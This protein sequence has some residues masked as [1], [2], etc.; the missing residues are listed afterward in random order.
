MARNTKT[1]EAAFL[2]AFDLDG[3]GFDGAAVGLGFFKRREVLFGAFLGLAAAAVA[4]AGEGA[5]AAGVA[6]GEAAV[7]AAA[8]A[9]A[10]VAVAGATVA[11]V[12][13][14][15]PAAGGL[16]SQPKLEPSNTKQY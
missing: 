12:T 6:A 5:A 14:A 7:V 9:E 13:R 10:A 8:A 16:T 11:A 4:P 15:V 1:Y 3:S 2:S